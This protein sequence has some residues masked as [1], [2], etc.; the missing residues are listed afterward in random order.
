MKCSRFR[1]HDYKKI[2]R[3]VNYGC[4]FEELCEV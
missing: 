2:K 1:P 3:E 4:G